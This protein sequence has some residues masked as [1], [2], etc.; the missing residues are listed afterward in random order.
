MLGVREEHGKQSE[1][2]N[3]RRNVTCAKNVKFQGKGKCQM[4]GT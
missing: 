4:E 3:Q 2:K 1:E